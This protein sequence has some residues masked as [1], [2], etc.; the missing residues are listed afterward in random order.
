MVNEVNQGVNTDWMALPLHLGIGQRHNLRLEGGDN[1]FRYSASAQI[2]N[3]EGVMK[4][5]SHKTFNGTINLTYR[6]KTVQFTNSLMVGIENSTQSPY[7]TFSDYVSMNPY[8]RPYDSTGRVNKFLGYPGNSDYIDRYNPLPTNPLYNATLNGFDKTSTS[9]IVNNFSIEWAITK[10]FQFRSRIG[11]TKDISQ[12]NKFRS[13]D[14]TAFANYAIADIFRK[15]D[16]AY[17]VSNGFAYDGS[18]SLSYSTRIA[19]K[20]SI[21][22]GVDYNMR[23]NKNS[24]YSY[25]AE[26]FSNANFDFPSMALQYAQGGKPGGSENLTR[27]VGLTA[28]MNYTYDNRYY[29]DASVRE[30]GSSQFGSKQRFAPFWSTG[31]GWNLHQEKFL[32]NNEIINRLKIR[33]SLGVTGSQS[34]SAYQAL[35]TYQYYTN[36]RYYNWMGAYLLGLG[37]D[38]LK[39]Q[40]KMN[41]DLG[42]ETQLFKQRISFIFDYYIGTT[43]DLVSSINL[44]PSNGSPAMLKT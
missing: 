23:Q 1:T 37:N 28:S 17:G 12:S 20:H 18:I 16:Y 26:G 22:A 13:A 31:I 25:L 21:F 40:Q 29:I 44:P 6:Y 27:A 33:G 36:D 32:K 19:D 10:D 38:E 15:G 24:A 2:N 41:Y 4:G 9:S 7:G 34:F 42:L 14:N 39:W 11:L 35:S 3:V 8:W 43:K 5:S 30:D